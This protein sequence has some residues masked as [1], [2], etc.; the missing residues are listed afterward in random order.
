MN[1]PPPTLI[2]FQQ[3]GRVLEH[4]V[5][6]ADVADTTST[7]R[8][9]CRARPLTGPVW[10]SES[11][12]VRMTVMRFVVVI[13]FAGCGSSGGGATQPMEAGA[14]ADTGGP[15]VVTYQ[16]VKPIFATK[17]VPCHVTGG[18]GAP[19]HT[20]AESYATAKLPSGAC[21]AKPKGECTLILVKSGYMPFMKG[22]SGD[23]TK[24]S[25]NPAWLT[26]AEHQLLA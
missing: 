2:T 5:R 13:L 9:R 15:K 20:L 18:Q 3:K 24:D 19:F 21:S 23:P 26:A 12:P 10:M 25:A 17:C 4:A 7:T 8:E 22:C 14:S 16:D 6:H 11:D 1:Q